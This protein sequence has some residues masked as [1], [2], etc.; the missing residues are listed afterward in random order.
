MPNHYHLLVRSPLGNVSS[1]MK[2]LG[3]TYTQGFNRRHR[4]DGSLFR[5]RQTMGIHLLT[6]DTGPSAE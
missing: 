6:G 2:H 1:A 4:R 3:A 5:G